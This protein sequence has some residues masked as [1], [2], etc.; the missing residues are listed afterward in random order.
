[1]LTY[2]TRSW[3]SSTRYRVFDQY[4]SRCEGDSPIHSSHGMIGTVR[5]KSSRSASRTRAT[6]GC[7]QKSDQ[8]ASIPG[9]LWSASSIKKPGVETRYSWNATYR[10][11]PGYPKAISRF[12]GTGIGSLISPKFSGWTDASNSSSIAIAALNSLDL[13]QVFRRIGCIRRWNHTVKQMP[14]PFRASGHQIRLVCFLNQPQ[15]L[16]FPAGHS[17]T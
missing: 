4:S 5:F 2:S 6:A 3:R 8:P 1:M 13:T 12:G 16:L 15:G 10:S 7:L 11:S 17:N 14:E 9:H